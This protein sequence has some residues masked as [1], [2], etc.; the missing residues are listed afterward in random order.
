MCCCR[1]YDRHDMYRAGAIRPQWDCGSRRNLAG[2]NWD[3]IGF[4]FTPVSTRNCLAF[5]EHHFSM[6]EVYDGLEP[7]SGGAF[8]LQGAGIKPSPLVISGACHA[9]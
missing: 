5:C 9:I 1:Q 4:I 2:C 6:Q 8:L 7:R 3:T